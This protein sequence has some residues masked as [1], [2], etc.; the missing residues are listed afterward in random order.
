V[1]SVGAGVAR[2]GLSAVS[3]RSSEVPAVGSGGPT[4]EGSVGKSG[5]TSSLRATR[6]EP[7][8]GRRSRKF[9]STARSSSSA[10]GAV[11][12]VLGLVEPGPSA[13]LL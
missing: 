3:R 12:V 1:G 13:A 6:L 10:N 7:R 5:S 11:V 2:V 4:R 8:F 9:G